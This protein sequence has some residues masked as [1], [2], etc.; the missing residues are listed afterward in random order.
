VHQNGVNDPW[1]LVISRPEK[2]KELIDERKILE[3][4]ARPI[5]TAVRSPG[6]ALPTMS[7]SGASDGFF[8]DYLPPAA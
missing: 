2:R 6:V 7:A 5:V 3:W 1:R 8:T 4:R